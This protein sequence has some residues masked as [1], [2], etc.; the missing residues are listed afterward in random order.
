MLSERDFRSLGG[1][2]G[3]GG[4]GSRHAGGG[5]RERRLLGLEE[6]RVQQGLRWNAVRHKTCSAH[7]LIH[8]FTQSF[9]HTLIQFIHSFSQSSLGCVRFM[10]IFG[11]LCKPNA[12]G[13]SAAPAPTTIHTQILLHA[14]TRKNGKQRVHACMRV[15][16]PARVPA[17]LP[18][19]LWTRR[20]AIGRPWRGSRRLRGGAGRGGRAPEEE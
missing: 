7:S 18:S 3:G 1:A 10:S 13:A 6:L 14:Y 19:R 15:H 11:L 20:R 9:M 8:A 4:G 5:G 16:A 12:T 2:S 17:F